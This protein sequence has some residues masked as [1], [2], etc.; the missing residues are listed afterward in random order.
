MKRLPGLFLAGQINGTT[1]Y[2]E[3]AGKGVVAGVNA[4]LKAGGGCAD[5]AISRT[6]AYIGV[7][8]DDLVTRGVSEP[9]RMF[10]SRAEYRLRLRADNADERLT[11]AWAAR[12]LRWP[13]ARG[14]IRRQS[15][16]AGF[17]AGA[18]GKADADAGRG[19]GP[20]HCAQSR[21]PAPLRFRSAFASRYER[22]CARRR[23]AGAGGDPGCHSGALAGRQRATPSAY[24]PAGG[25]H[26]R[27]QEGRGRC[28]P[29]HARFRGDM[30]LWNEI[31][32]KLERHRPSTLA[33]ASRIDGITP[34]AL[35]LVL[36]HIRKAS[37]AA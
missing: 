7:M 22:G 1:G 28:H 26:P 4:A 27:L 32:Q 19:G 12:R 3:A 15:G 25:E 18:A 30:G 6:E 24:G 14:G 13:G 34:A 33:Q 8:I 35:M 10:T 17:G 9:Y 20:W 21:R 29:C 2:E 11:P 37:R 31:R 16:C 23:L 5:F 36:A